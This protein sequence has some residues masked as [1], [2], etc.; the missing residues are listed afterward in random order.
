MNAGERRDGECVSRSFARGACVR[1]PVWQQFPCSTSGRS[2]SLAESSELLVLQSDLQ[3]TWNDCASLQGCALSQ[4]LGPCMSFPAS[5][6]PHLCCFILP[7]QGFHLHMENPFPSGNGYGNGAPSP[8]SSHPHTQLELLPFSHWLPNSLAVST[9]LV[10]PLRNQLGLSTCSS[11]TLS[12]LS[13]CF[14]YEIRPSL[15]YLH[16]FCCGRR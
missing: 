4:D 15:L 7:L 2:S 1:V 11:S 9:L 5:R 14:M 3:C 12:L 13:F 10:Q 8:T 16:L 6:N